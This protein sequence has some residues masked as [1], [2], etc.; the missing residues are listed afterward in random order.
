MIEI[1]DTA[2]IVDV[3]PAEYN[4]LLG[5]PR[6]RVPS[7]RATELAAWAREWYAQHG[8]PWVYARRAEVQRIGDETIV[9]EDVALRSARL[10]NT[11]H[12]AGAHAAMLVA[13][14]A[15]PEVEQEAQARWR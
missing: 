8:H 11:F 9:I 2:P 1:H 3:Q 14:S 12:D 5:Y 4:R 10:R 6:G 7:E 13:V 15:G